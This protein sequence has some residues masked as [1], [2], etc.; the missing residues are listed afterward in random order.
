MHQ[1]FDSKAA[2][3]GE[4]IN[5]PHMVK[6]IHVGHGDTQLNSNS[7]LG[8]VNLNMNVGDGDTQ[9]QTIME[10]VNLNMNVGIQD[11]DEMMM[12]MLIPQNVE[13]TKLPI[14]LNPTKHIRLLNILQAKKEKWVSIL[15]DQRW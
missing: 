7:I 10:D 1:I 6:I 4:Q 9:P 8:D 3:D 13:M 15:L 14:P 2:E 12:N 5:E 11:E